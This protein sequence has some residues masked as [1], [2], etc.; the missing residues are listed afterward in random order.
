MTAGIKGASLVTFEELGH[1]PQ[2]EARDRFNAA[3]LQA[4]DVLLPGRP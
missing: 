1:A 3:L 2:I 4:L